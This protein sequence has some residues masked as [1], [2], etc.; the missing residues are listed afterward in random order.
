MAVIALSASLL[1]ACL[2]PVVSVT[3]DAGRPDVTHLVLHHQ[4]GATSTVTVTLS[5]PDAAAGFDMYVWGERGRSAAPPE[6]DHAQQA[7]RVA[8]TELAD[9]ARSGQVSHPCDVQFG[10]DVGRVLAEAQRQV[11]ARRTP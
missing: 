5:A 2:G 8:L 7:L 1:W 4:G 11:D 3:A 6:E 9:N 10:R